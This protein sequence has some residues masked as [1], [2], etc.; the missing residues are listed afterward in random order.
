[1][2]AAPI[3]HPTPCIC[4]ELLRRIIIVFS[5]FGR[6]KGSNAGSRGANPEITT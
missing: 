5:Y 1:M 4:V 2:G 6:S 3:A